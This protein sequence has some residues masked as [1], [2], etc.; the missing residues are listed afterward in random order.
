MKHGW[1][2]HK[3]QT[4]STCQ[5]QEMDYFMIFTQK[6]VSGFLQWGYNNQIIPFFRGFSILHQAFLKPG[7]THPTCPGWPCH[8]RPRAG[9]EGEP[10]RCTVDTLTV[11]HQA[12]CGVRVLMEFSFNIYIHNY[13]I[14]KHILMEW[15]G[16]GS[17][18]SIKGDHTYTL[19]I[20][21]DGWVGD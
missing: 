15:G 14:H 11:N 8:G 13:I 3:Q 18:P 9:G 4:R 1:I 17:Y 2:L 7:L 19:V 5:P 21:E 6:I 16:K 20:K 12:I 10:D